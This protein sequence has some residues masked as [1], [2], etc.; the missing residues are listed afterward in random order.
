MNK[1]KQLFYN[2]VSITLVV[3]LM[4]GC[5]LIPTIKDNLM[6]GDA[7]TSTEVSKHEIP[8]F[9]GVNY[10]III[11]NNKTYFTSEEL[12]SPVDLFE[13]SDFDELGRCWPAIAIAS[14]DTIAKT[15]RGSIGMIKPSG[16][17]TVRYDD[18]IEGKYLYN[19]SHLLMFAALDGDSNGRTNTENN[20][21]TGTRFFNADTDHGMLHYETLLLNYLQSDKNN[22]LYRVTP[23]FEGENLVAKGVLMEAKSIE[24]NGEDL[25]FCVFIYNEQPK[26][27]IDHATGDSHV[28]TQ[29]EL[30]ALLN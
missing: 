18:L 10:D 24:D 22:V 27:T 1:I 29:E 7:L 16:W 13:L 14:Y 15:E 11:N 4:T 8:A 21:I 9:D 19:R 30:D 25:E 20:L 28:Q 2:V 5:N 26:I 23:I 3:T 6:R 12:N 17:H